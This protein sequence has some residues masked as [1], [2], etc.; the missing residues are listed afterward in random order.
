MGVSCD[1]GIFSGFWVSFWVNVQG[2]LGSFLC[3]LHDFD[4]KIMKDEHI[5]SFCSNAD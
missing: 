1:L 4:A 5:L 2:V 3:F